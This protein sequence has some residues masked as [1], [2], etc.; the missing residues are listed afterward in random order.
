MKFNMSHRRRRQGP[1]FRI[2]GRLIDSIFPAITADRLALEHNSFSRSLRIAM[3]F[4]S[5]PSGGDFKTTKMPPG[6][7]CASVIGPG[8]RCTR[9]RQ[10]PAV[11]GSNE[12]HGM[13]RK[14]LSL[15]PWQEPSPSIP[16]TTMST[17]DVACPGR[18]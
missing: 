18:P 7:H 17:H 3:G 14:Q 2:E 6:E 11:S 10:I 12:L 5:N 8:A 4:Y 16:G 9:P 1:F 15:G 13:E